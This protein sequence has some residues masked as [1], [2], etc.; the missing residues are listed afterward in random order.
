MLAGGGGRFRVNGEVDVLMTIA[1]VSMQYDLSADTLRYYERVG[2]IPPVNRTASGIRNYTESDCKWVEFAKCMRAAGLPVE[3]L[4]K[5]VSLFQ[6]GDIT[7]D[8]RKQILI[9]QRDQLQV[10]MDELQTT[11]ERLDK[12]IRHYEDVLLPCEQQLTNRQAEH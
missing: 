12:K 3:A 9:E 6:K 10:K 5:Y 11:L 4:A 7:I 1:E 8:E 2:L